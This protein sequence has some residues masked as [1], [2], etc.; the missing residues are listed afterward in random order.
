MNIR[1]THLYPE[2]MNLYGDLGNVIALKRR[3]EARGIDVKVTDV[4]VGDKLKAGVTDIYFF[5]G[6]QDKQQAEIAPDLISLKKEALLK[7]LWDGVVALAICGGYQLLGQYYLTGEG[8]RAEG[9]GFLP[10]ETVA[11]G[12]DVQQRCIGN[13][14]TKIVHKKTLKEIKEY[15]NNE[16][17]G[18]KDLHSLVGFENHSGRTRVLEGENLQIGKVIK[19]IGD[20]EGGGFEGLRY[21]NTFGSYMHGSFLPKNPHMADLLISLALKKKYGTK[22]GQLETLNDTLEWQAH[23]RAT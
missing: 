11:P 20:S 7:D 1:I 9:V 5:G 22:F 23:E 12:P 19:G 14:S 4:K 8:E 10:I 15:Y 16:N 6:G 17:V 18:H 3:A 2:E 13:I 21:K